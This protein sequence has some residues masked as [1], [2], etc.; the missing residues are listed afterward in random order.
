MRV[1]LIGVSDNTRKSEKGRRPA[2]GAISV[3]PLKPTA[4]ILNCCLAFRLFEGAESGDQ[5]IITD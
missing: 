5:I 4:E 1:K 3:T 2:S